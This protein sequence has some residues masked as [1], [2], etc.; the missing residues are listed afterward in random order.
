MQVITPITMQAIAG[1]VVA[2]RPGLAPP[3]R[4]ELTTRKGQPRR[5]EDELIVGLEAIDKSQAVKGLAR[6]DQEDAREDHEQES[7]AY[8]RRGQK[9]GARQK[10]SLDIAG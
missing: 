3:T 2:Q 1:S 10:P 6:N 5:D 8:S 4:R 7:G 9:L